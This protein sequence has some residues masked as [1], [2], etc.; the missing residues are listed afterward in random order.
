MKYLFL[1]L[2]ICTNTFANEP[3]QR[4]S[5]EVDGIPIYY[6]LTLP[7]KKTFPL[8]V[9]VQGSTCESGLQV[10]DKL[11][12]EKYIDKVA[13]LIV[14]KPGIEKDTKEC[15]QSYLKHNSIDFRVKS[16]LKVIDVLKSKI[17]G[18][19]R[20]AL[21]IGGSEGGVV[22]SLAAAQTS[23]TKALSILVTG[24]GM[25]MAEN[26]LLLTEKQMKQAKAPQVAIDAQLAKTKEK[27]DEIRKNP[28]WEKEWM[29]DNKLAR[30]TYKWWSSILDIRLSEALLYLGKPI[31][32]VHGDSDT[33]TSV[34]SADQLAELFK[35]RKKT[36]LV[37]KKYVGIGHDFKNSQG[38]LQQ[39][40]VDLAMEWLITTNFK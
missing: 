11:H 38:Q 33:S 18:W 39:E 29:S 5:T 37:Y 24:G 16:Y 4:S 31:Y 17:N 23:E 36:N 3:S 9:L 21:W 13:T 30:N 26:I 14:E 28:T 10:F 34:E 6:Y 25:S 19:N 40:I 15:P 35:N 2:L 8:V 22:A 1:L 12:A 27:F 32:M 20:E 7:S